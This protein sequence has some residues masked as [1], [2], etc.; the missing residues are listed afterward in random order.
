[1]S[2]KEAKSGR[3]IWKGSWVNDCDRNV[4]GDTVEGLVVCV[5]RE[6]VPQAS[7]EMKTG[8]ALDLQ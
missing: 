2:R 1:M 5:G 7:N 8:R 4:D 6:E 3:I